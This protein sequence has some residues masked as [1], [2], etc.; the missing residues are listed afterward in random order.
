MKNA[1]ALDLPQ[2]IATE[3]SIAL[4]TAKFHV[5]NILCKLQVDKRT[6]AVLMALKH[7]IAP[8]A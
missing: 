5:S 4:P 1:S 6:E 2:E 7:Q 8:S 3:L